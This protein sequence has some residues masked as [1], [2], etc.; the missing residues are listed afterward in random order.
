[1]SIYCDRDFLLPSRVSM[2]KCV[3]AGLLLALAS[4]FPMTD[5]TFAETYTLTNRVKPTEAGINGLPSGKKLADLTSADTLNV[6]GGNA[7]L[8]FDSSTDLNCNIVISGNANGTEKTGKF[9]L[10]NSSTVVNLNGMVTLAGD[11]AIGSHAWQGNQGKLYFNNQIT[12]TGALLI[13]PSAASS[14]YLNNTTANKNNYAGNTQIGNSGM[15]NNSGVTNY[16][17][18]VYLQADEQI[19]DALTAGVS[20]VGNLVLMS[21]EDTRLRSKLDLDGHTET[22]NGLVSA[23]TWS[24]VTSS[25]AGGK[26]IVGANN[27]TSEFKGMLQGSMA[28]EKI[29]T[30][31]LTLSGANTY[32]GGTTVTAGTLR[33]TNASTTGTGA[34]S[35]A[36]GAV[37]EIAAPAEETVW[38]GG[39]ISGSGTLKVSGDG[40]FTIPMANFQM[41]GNAGKLVVDGA[42]LTLNNLTNSTAYYSGSDILIDNAGSLKF[43]YTGSANQIWLSNQTNITFG[44]SGGGTFNTGNSSEVDLNFVNNSTTKFISTGGA[45]NYISGTNGFNLHGQNITFD[46]AKGTAADGNDLIVSAR[47][48]NNHGIVK[49]GA[50]TMV[51]TAANSNFR[52]NVTINA[53][54]IIASTNSSLGAVQNGKSVFVNQGAELSLGAQDVF[55]NAHSNNAVQFVV[56]GGKIS[57]TGAVY[58][59]L[60]NTTFKDGAELHAVDGNAVWKAFKLHNVNVLRNDDGSAAA[61]VRFTSAPNSP[62]AVIGFGDITENIENGTSTLNIQDITSA[63]ASVSDDLPDLII[64][65]VVADPTINTQTQETRPTAVKKTGSGMLELAAANTFTGQFTVSEGVLRLSGDALAVKA[66]IA[67]EANG[68]LDLNVAEGAGK[69]FSGKVTGMGRAVKSGV[70][71]LTLNTANGFEASSLNVSAGRAN[72]VGTLSGDL[73]IADGAVFSPGDGIGTLTVNGDFT[74]GDGAKLVFE[75]GADAS[76]LLILGSESALDIADDAV[77]ELL[78]TDADTSKTYTLIEANGGWGEYADSAFWTDILLA[79]DTANWELAIVG[80]TLQAFISADP[81]VPEPAT[82]ALLVLGAAG[83]F[84]VRKKRAF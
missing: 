30:G 63:N 9:R 16:G 45:A 71:T 55:A 51:L 77:L 28:L 43:A 57:N 60:Q 50:G 73:A 41:D 53:G 22:V 18:S 49:D 74:V 59:Y 42:D 46:V 62:N 64:S 66:P 69:A 32:T 33:L 26:L 79:A 27:A 19:P 13:A 83:L 82:W 81:S 1:M 72:V 20:S 11:T 7:Q 80:N 37:F 67:L 36:S 54:K 6:T 23:D 65:G 29:G 14:V 2:G 84:F 39:N 75:L 76:D 8:Y 78:F 61:P 47:L 12:G 35:I 44:A 34:V 21:W 56:D 4:A 68:T 70:G 48:W 38:N 58:N 31:T 3:S 10:Q 24:V 40:P 25:A 15:Y 5:S 17:G 52:G